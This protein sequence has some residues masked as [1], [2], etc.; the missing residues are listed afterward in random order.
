[1]G[2][3]RTSDFDYDLP[4][5]YVAYHPSEKR[6][7][8]RLLVLDRAS[9]AIEHRVFR[10][11]PAYFGASDLLVVN[12]TRVIKA[13]VNARKRGT[14]GRVEVLFLREA[15]D[16]LWLAVVSPSRRVHEGTALELESGGVIKIERRLAGAKRLVR[17]DVPD[18]LAF[19]RKEGEVPLPPYIRRD[20]VQEDEE[21]YQTVFAEP[22]GSV[23]APTAGLHFTPEI[24]VRL[25]QEGCRIARI[26]LHVG[27][28]T[29]IPVKAEMPEEHVLE[30]EYFEVG[31]EAAQAIDSARVG[32]GRIAA[33]GTTSVRVLETLA[34]RRE[35][36]GAEVPLEPASGWTAKYIYPPYEFRL[37]DTLITN[38]HLPRSTLLM[39]VCAFAGREFVLNAY[40][41][42]VR[43]K[44]RFYSYGDAMLIV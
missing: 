26:T 35:A 40:E 8:S 38:F 33:V 44:Y 24:I 4:P 39:L 36:A 7:E 25:E 2:E 16:G 41:E 13:R 18:V 11:L 14:G 28:G 23:A 9:G 3:A 31:E 12:D 22:E 20:P 6:E 17:L 19:L 5:G 27:L 1:L 15:Q 21:R 29:F 43:E 42:A 30:P 10:D 34:D 37:V 32:G